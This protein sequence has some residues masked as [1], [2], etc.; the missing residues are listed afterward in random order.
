MLGNVLQFIKI[1]PHADHTKR[2]AARHLYEKHGFKLTDEQ[3][4]NMWGVEVNE[5]RFECHF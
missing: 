4:G 5:Q 3:R 1:H 2:D